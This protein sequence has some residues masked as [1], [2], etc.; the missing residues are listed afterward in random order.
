MEA[1]ALVSPGQGSQGIGT[2][3]RPPG[4][5]RPPAPR[6]P[7]RT[8][9]WD[10]ASDQPGDRYADAVPRWNPIDGDYA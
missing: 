6:R 3:Q 9:R 4:D 10:A 5:H 1:S 7:A 2:D 8:T